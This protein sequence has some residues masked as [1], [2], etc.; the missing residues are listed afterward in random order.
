MF[1]MKKAL[2]T[3]SAFLNLWTIVLGLKY[4]YIKYNSLSVPNV[5]FLNQIIIYRLE[6]ICIDVQ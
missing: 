4:T 6:Y 5:L 1:L 2:G 3:Q